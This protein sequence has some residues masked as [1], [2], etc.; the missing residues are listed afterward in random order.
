VIHDLMVALFA[1][2][3][4]GTIGFTIWLVALYARAVRADKK[5]EQETGR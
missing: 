1:A 5:R 2:G 3:G 4:L